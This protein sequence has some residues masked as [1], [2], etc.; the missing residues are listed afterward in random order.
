[1]KK[2]VTPTAAVAS[3]VAEAWREVGTSFERFC[4][5]AGIATL[6]D[7]MERDA[8]DLCGPRYG[9]ETAAAVI[10]GGRLP[11]SSVSTVARCRSNGPVCEPATAASWRCRA[12]RRPR[13]RAGWG[14]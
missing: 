9:R 12:G 5:T 6:V 14:D 10:A 8:A 7:M 4:L 1:M 13:P 11:A 2:D 3:G